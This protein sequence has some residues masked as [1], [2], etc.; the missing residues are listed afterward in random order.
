[1]PSPKFWIVP[2]LTV[3]WPTLSRIPLETLPPVPL[4]ENPFRSMVTGE[5]VT[6]MALVSADSYNEIAR[7]TVAARVP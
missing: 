6:L 7:Q 5:A 3:N 4:I 1:M 2:F